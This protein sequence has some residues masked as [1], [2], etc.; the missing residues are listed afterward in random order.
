VR[1]FHIAALLLLTMLTFGCSKNI[2]VN[3]DGMPIST[4]EYNLTNDETKVRIVFILA[5]YHRDYEGKEYIVKPEYLDALHAHRIDSDTIERLALHIKVINLRKQYYV[6]N[7]E[8]D[9][10]G[11]NDTDGVLYAGK[12]SRKDFLLRL[13]TAPSGDYI[14][15]FSVSDKDGNDL[16]D[17]PPMRYKVKGGVDK[18]HNE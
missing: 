8:V 16:F 10:P 18:L 14:Y 4:H 15:S 13:P 12:L 6:V 9:Q 3:V 17:L 7:W 11:D 1:T 2:I 5:S